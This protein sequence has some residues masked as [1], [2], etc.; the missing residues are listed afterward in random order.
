MDIRDGDLG[1]KGPKPTAPTAPTA[2]HRRQVGTALGWLLTFWEPAAAAW[3]DVGALKVACEYAACPVPRVR[4]YVSE[5]A[6]FEA[7]AVL[8]WRV[9]GRRARVKR[10]RHSRPALAL[11]GIGKGGR[12][13]GPS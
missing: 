2:D 6:M 7:L 3:E 5:A 13:P 1:G 11:W 9:T 4:L 8:G 10:R 12:G